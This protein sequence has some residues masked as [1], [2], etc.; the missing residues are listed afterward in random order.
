VPSAAPA[1]PP[2]RRL[3]IA[4]AREISSIFRAGRRLKTPDFTVIYRSTHAPHT[5]FGVLVGRRLG[6]AVVRNRIKRRCRELVRQ[7][8]MQRGAY[9]V[10][11]LPRATTAQL[12]FATLRDRLHAALEEL[13]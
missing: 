3:R 6:G 2:W 11:L 9:D 5:R 12:P 1:H 10:L 8:G 4:D 7:P 13:E